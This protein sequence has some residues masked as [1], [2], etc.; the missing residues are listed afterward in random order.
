MKIELNLLENSYDFIINSFELYSTALEYGIHDPKRSRVDNKVKWKLAFI[1]MVQ[2]IEL[3]LKEVLF[4][5]HPNLIYLNI[6]SYNKINFKTVSFQQ[7]INRVLNFSEKPIDQ[8]DVIFLINCAKLRNEFI[9]YKVK[10]QSE[11]I[12]PK[13]SALYNIYKKLYKEF[14]Q[15]EITFTQ[16]KYQHIEGNILQ[17]NENMTIYRG[18]EINKNEAKLI[19]EELE[20]NN[21]YK[22]YITKDGKKIPRIKFGD[23]LN[24]VSNKFKEIESENFAMYEHYDVCDECL[25][26]HGDYHLD[27]CDLEICPACSKQLITCGCIV[28]K[29]K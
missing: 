1:T 4:R 3:L 26:K 24:Y 10:I 9:H 25:A 18:F 22:F 29:V 8:E 15:E 14:F 13:Y 16:Q 21:K 20:E 28:K 2:A 27:G 5:I 11:Q 17:F 19:Q 6:D 23:E 7:A 12:S